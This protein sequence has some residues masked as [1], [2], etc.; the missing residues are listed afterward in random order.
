[1]K[2]SLFFVYLSVVFLLFA[3]GS[4]QTKKTIDAKP[5]LASALA[6]ENYGKAL[7]LRTK[8]NMHNN[9]AKIVNL[10]LKLPAGNRVDVNNELEYLQQFY[11]SFSTIH[12]IIYDDIA[13]WAAL[14]QI[15]QYEVAPP[16]R[17]LQRDQLYLAKSRI[18]FHKCPS[19][20]SSCAKKARATIANL[21]SNEEI[22]TVL[23]RMS[24]KDPCVNLSNELKGQAIANRCLSKSKGNLKIELLPEP[25]FNTDQWLQAIS[26]N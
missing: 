18:N 4:P 15:Y 8:A 24:L 10:Y 25:R 19:A 14:Q 6:H 7:S 16:I 21:M 1:M 20:N 3:C 17:I 12:K 23:K 9:A 2:I 11:P 13:K 26:S 22:V 5:E